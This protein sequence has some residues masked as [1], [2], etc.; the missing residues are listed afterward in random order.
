MA[1]EYFHDLAAFVAVAEEQTFTRAATKIGVSQSALSQT[2][3]GLEA[4]L[5]IRLLTR[6]TRRVAPT[7]VGAPAPERGTPL[8]GD[9]CRADRSQ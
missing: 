2:I 7:E 1:G 9:L 3:R 4:R 5:G 8:C 6:T